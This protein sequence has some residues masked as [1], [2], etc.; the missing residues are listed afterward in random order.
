MG[1]HHLLKVQEHFWFSPGKKQALTIR[2][3]REQLH[4][5]TCGEC[6]TIRE[7]GGPKRLLGYLG[8]L[9]VRRHLPQ[10]LGGY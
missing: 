7:V 8:Y 10:V 2:E 5:H 4:Q 1:M 6:L 3:V 9:G